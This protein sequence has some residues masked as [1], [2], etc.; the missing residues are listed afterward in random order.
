MYSFGTSFSDLKNEL[1]EDNVRVM[2]Q[3]HWIEKIMKERGKVGLLLLE[4][5]EQECEK[6]YELLKDRMHCIVIN[7]K[8]KIEDDEAGIAELKEK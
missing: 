8:T 7:G 2:T 3:I 5:R 4:R 6:Y 1:I